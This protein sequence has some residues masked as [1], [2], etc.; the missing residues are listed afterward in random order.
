M[1]RVHVQVVPVKPV[2]LV[3]MKR[4]IYALYHPCCRLDLWIVWVSMTGGIYCGQVRPGP[5]IP[6]ISMGGGTCVLTGVI[7]ITGVPWS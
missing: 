5:W 7:S 3:K 2:W 1:Q 4:S 6:W